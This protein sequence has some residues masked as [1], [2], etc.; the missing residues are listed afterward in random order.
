MRPNDWQDHK[1]LFD[2]GFSI[3]KKQDVKSNINSVTLKIAG[4]TKKRIKVK[5]QYVP[6]IPVQKENNSEITEIIYLKRFEYAPLKLGSVVGEARYYKEN[7][8]VCT[9]PVLTAEQAYQN[10]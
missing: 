6:I 10:K 3:V 8:L 9:I 4:G 1:K 2:Y 5:L 7:K